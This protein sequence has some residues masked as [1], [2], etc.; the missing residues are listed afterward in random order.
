MAGRRCNNC[1]LTKN[2]TMYK[3]IITWIIYSFVYQSCPYQGQV[4]EFGRPA[5]AFCTETHG[6]YVSNPK[7]KQITNKADAYSFYE[8]ALSYERPKDSLGNYLGEGIREVK[9][10]SIKIN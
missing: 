5:K 10:D 4:D 9:I 8:E 6:Y 7:Q 3:Y 1:P 2:T